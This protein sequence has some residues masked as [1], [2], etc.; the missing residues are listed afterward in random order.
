MPSRGRTSN[1]FLRGV[2]GRKNQSQSQVAVSYISIKIKLNT[3]FEY[4]IG[5]RIKLYIFD[6]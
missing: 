1:R 2:N 6:F 4:S 5:N 3:T